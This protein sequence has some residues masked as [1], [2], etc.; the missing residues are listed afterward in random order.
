MFS[1]PIVVHSRWKSI[2][3]LHRM[4]HAIRKLPAIRLLC[5]NRSLK[6]KTKRM[7]QAFVA[8]R[9]APPAACPAWAHQ[10]A[11]TSH[12]TFLVPSQ[13]SGSWLLRV[14]PPSLLTSHIIRQP[15]TFPSRRSMAPLMDLS[16][17]PARPAYD[18]GHRAM[19]DERGPRGNDFAQQILGTVAN[20][21][22]KPVAELDILDIGC[23]Y[24]HTA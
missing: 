13:A 20:D 18:I 7:E 11:V 9:S 24:G 14:L 5:S 16:Q 12:T 3:R 19:V 21:L 22:S 17:F 15:S 1:R 8:L 6:S 10:A 23:G 2:A 4:I